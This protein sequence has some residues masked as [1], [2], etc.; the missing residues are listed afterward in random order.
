[1]KKI[2]YFYNTHTLRYEKLVTP[3]RV[4]F[5]RFIAFIATAFVTAA[6][7]SYFAFQFVGSPNEKYLRIQNAQLKQD[8]EDLN[9]SVAQIQM[10]MAELEKR[11]N[12]VYRSIFEASPLPDSARATFLE[13]QNEIARVERMSGN[14]LVR[15]ISLTLNNLKSRIAAQKSSYNEIA[16]LINNKEKLLAATPAIQP[17]SNK[18]LNRIAS[19]FGYRIDPIY[20]TVKMHAGL[21]FTAAQG[22]PIYATANGVIKTAGNTGNGYG[23]HVVINHGYG[24]E[25]LY[26]HMVRVKARV[27]QR[28]ERGDLIGYVGSTGKS[29]GPHCHYEVHKNGQKLD[30]VYFFYNDLS[31]QQF[32]EL[33][34]RAS[35]SNQSF[36]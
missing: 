22:T 3:L 35:A 32:D 6:L 26:G 19:G 28:V 12:S 16:G 34:K 14:E 23:N 2:K 36:D 29:T 31:P 21:D 4:K 20:K 18:D 33:L 24:Y 9:D 1:M 27:G 7:I 17:V 15:S 8:F 13:K 10:K 11:D 5:L 25:T 30:P